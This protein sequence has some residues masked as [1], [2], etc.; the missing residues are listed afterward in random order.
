MLFWPSLEASVILV[1]EDDHLIQ[2]VIEEALKEGGSSLR[3]RVSTP[4]NCS[5]SP[6]ANTARSS[7]TSISDRNTVYMSGDSAED[8]AS[9]GVP[10]N[11][12]FAKPFAPAQLITQLLN[13]GTPAA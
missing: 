12:M 8:W 2:S 13:G 7:P 11:I 5:T 10:H 6:R 4:P 1:V 3:Q 9:H